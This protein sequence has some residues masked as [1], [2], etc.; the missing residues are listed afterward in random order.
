M[1]TV[2]EEYASL[3]VTLES[4]LTLP[5]VIVVGGATDKDGT[6]S[7]S[8]NLSTA[9]AAA[10]YR[11]L[12]IDPNGGTALSSELGIKAKAAPDL[13]LMS[14]SAVNGTIK[15]L[16]TVAVANNASHTTTSHLQMVSI[17]KDLRGMYDITIVDAG[18]VPGN[19]LALQFASAS[20][21]MIL[22]FRLGRKPVRADRDLSD[23]LGRVGAAVL[24]VVAVGREADRRPEPATRPAIPMEVVPATQVPDL[25]IPTPAMQT[26]AEVIA[27]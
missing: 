6:A 13:S 15:N 14:I 4:A 8:C 17:L 22:S 18:T 19:P 12:L 23:A 27:R 24:G 26:H 9:F 2:T 10:G 7:V 20:Q 16:S 25:T 11:T 1:K 21:G 3:R 5:A